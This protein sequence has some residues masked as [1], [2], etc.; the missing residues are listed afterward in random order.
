MAFTEAQQPTKRRGRAK[1]VTK[2]EVDAAR[3]RLRD[4]AAAGDL[5]ACAALIALVERRPSLPGEAGAV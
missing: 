5:Q 3:E 4:A 2:H 1:C